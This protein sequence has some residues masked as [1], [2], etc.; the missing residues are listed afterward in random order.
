MLPPGHPRQFL[1][2]IKARKAPA[3]GMTPAL[4]EIKAAEVLSMKIASFKIR[5]FMDLKNT[6]A[7]AN[8]VM[9]PGMG[10][11]N[12]ASLRELLSRMK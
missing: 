1:S 7:R 2:I 5:H 8:R 11:F 12:L 10:D 3:P 6:T 9:T 4:G